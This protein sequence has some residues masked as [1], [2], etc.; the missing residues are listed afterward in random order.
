[1]D[2][3]FLHPLTF[4]LASGFQ[5]SRGHS[6]ITSPAPT[7]RHLLPVGLLRSRFMKRNERT[8]TKA[9]NPRG[10]FVHRPKSSA[11]KILWWPEKGGYCVFFFWAVLT[12]WNSQ[13]RLK[14]RD[15]IKV[16]LVQNVSVLWWGRIKTRSR[17]PSSQARQSSCLAGTQWQASGGAL[18]KLIYRFPP[19]LF[20]AFH[21]P[22]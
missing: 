13:L 3:I 9:Q 10:S 20:S 19:S 12:L 17:L 5:R 22:Y 8:N 15:W 1:M 14:V 6:S 16:I 21:A 7:L 2:V 11:W 18:Q 4:K